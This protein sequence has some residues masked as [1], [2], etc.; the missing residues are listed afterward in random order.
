MNYIGA[1]VNTSATIYGV[2][3]TEIKNGAGKAVKF[4]SD[5]KVVL[6]STAGEAAIGVLIAQTPDVVAAG[7]EVTIQIKDIGPAVAAAAIAVGAEVTVDANGKVKTAASGNAVLGQAMTSA[8]AD[9]DFVQIQ[10]TK[11][12]YKA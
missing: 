10:I 5:G 1:S 6:C 3:A 7:D 11:T 2:V 9:G 4:N 12:G 8:S